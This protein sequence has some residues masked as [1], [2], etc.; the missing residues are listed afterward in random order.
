MINGTWYAP[1]FDPPRFFR[2]SANAIASTTLEPAPVP[3]MTP[4]RGS[5]S[6]SS[7]KPAI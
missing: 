2:R 5:C 7:L 4:V 1:T 3:M 6:C